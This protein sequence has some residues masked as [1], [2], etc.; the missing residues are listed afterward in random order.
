LFVGMMISTVT[1]QWEGRS[2]LPATQG[3]SRAVTLLAAFGLIGIGLVYL[4]SP[5]GAATG[6]GREWPARLD[7]QWLAES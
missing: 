6:C 4:S 2:G 7:G 3:L 5:G 1:G